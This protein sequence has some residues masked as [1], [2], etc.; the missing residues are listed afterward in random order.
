MSSDCPTVTEI[1]YTT[2]NAHF[3]HHV[4]VLEFVWSSFIWKCLKKV[5]TILY[6]AAKETLVEYFQ[7]TSLNGFGLLYSI[8]RRKYQRLFWFTFI[9]MGVTFATYVCSTTLISFLKDP[10]VTAL[11]T[12]K[13]T[14]FNVP[15]PS[16]AVCSN[17]KFSREAILNYALDITLRSPDFNPPE[18]WQHKLKQLAGLLNTDSTD[19]DEALKLHNNLESVF[20]EAFN[21]RKILKMLAPKCEDLIVKC[22]WAGEVIDCQE[23]FQLMSF[24]DGNCCVFNYQYKNHPDSLYYPNSIGAEMGLTVLLNSTT[25]DYFYAEESTIGFNVKLFGSQRIPDI[26]MGEMEE[27]H[28][29]PGEDVDVKLSLVSQ[30]TVKDARVHSV[31]KR[32]CY[33]PYEHKEAAFDKSEC[34]LKCKIRSIE[35]LC[36]CIPFYASNSDIESKKVDEIREQCTLANSECL[37]RYRVTWQTYYP[38]NADINSH[39][40]EMLADSLTCP[41]CLPLCNYNRYFYRKVVNRL[42]HT[43]KQNVNRKYLGPISNLPRELSLVKIFYTSE[44]AIRY[45]KNV[46][47]NWYQILSN[48]GGVIGICM[49]CSIISGIEII[50]FGCYRLVEKYLKLKRNRK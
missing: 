22:F 38:V 14:V 39:L 20:G 9:V 46:L 6:A 47:Y 32:G 3:G 45:Q 50:Y 37:E 4:K 29:C 33:F 43:F 44:S 35:S 31:L 30:S 19:F 34:L 11:N 1:P 2:S 26:S 10:T 21:T 36:N 42:R 18:Y 13:Y 23:Q 41:D 7:K 48:I 40:K 27:F 49:G 12:Q 17:N 5:L 28:V 8:R 25:S 15:F 24:V 16:V